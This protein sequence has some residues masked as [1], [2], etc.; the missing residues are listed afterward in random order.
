[1]K[2]SLPIKLIFYGIL[3]RAVVILRKI[4]SVMSIVLEFNCPANKPERK[5]ALLSLTHEAA[6]KNEPKKDV[7]IIA[8]RRQFM[9][10][11]EFI[12]FRLEARR[13]I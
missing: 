10:S 13:D 1:M 8:G 6:L 12:C 7:P 5:T 4:R 9:N 2:G 11:H 3:K